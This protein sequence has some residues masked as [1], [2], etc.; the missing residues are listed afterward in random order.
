MTISRSYRPGL[1]YGLWCPTSEKWQ[2]KKKKKAGL[3]DHGVATDVKK[4]GLWDRGMVIGR[5]GQKP[6]RQRPS[7]FKTSPYW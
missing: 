3:W 2:K 5:P 4:P 6:E 7:S 1:W